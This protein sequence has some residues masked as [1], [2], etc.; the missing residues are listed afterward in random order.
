MTSKGPSRPEILI[1]P[2]GA[3]HSCLKRWTDDLGVFLLG[4][5]LEGVYA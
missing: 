3:H 1:D 2:R 4:S 5:G